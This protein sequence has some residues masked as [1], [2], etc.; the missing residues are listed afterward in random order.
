[1][2]E[3]PTS[4][5][6]DLCEDISYGVTASASD[7]ADGPLFLRTTDIV[8]PRIDWATVP[9]CDIADDKVER[10]EPRSQHGSA[11]AARPSGC[12]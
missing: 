4:T 7:K 2:A 5:L 10:F 3:W 1:M 12:G 8:P 9:T 6:A 11:T